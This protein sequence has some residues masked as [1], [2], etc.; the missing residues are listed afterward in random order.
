MIRKITN[1]VWEYVLYTAF[2]AFF[3]I[4]SF[5]NFQKGGFGKKSNLTVFCQYMPHFENF[6]DFFF[7]FLKPIFFLELHMNVLIV[8]IDN[9]QEICK[10]TQ[11]W[12]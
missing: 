6:I 11:I 10:N 12:G 5:W 2:E 4:I 7:F 8:H 3:I 9:K 1:F